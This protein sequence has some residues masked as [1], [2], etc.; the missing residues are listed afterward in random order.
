MGHLTRQSVYYQEHKLNLESSFACP[1]AWDLLLT[2]LHNTTDRELF[3]KLAAF[4]LVNHCPTLFFLIAWNI[5]F[6]R[7]LGQLV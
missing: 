4:F 7:W 1:A 3:K 6:H 5:L 2:K